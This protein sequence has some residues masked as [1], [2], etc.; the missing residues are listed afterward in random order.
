MRVPERLR[1]DVEATGTRLAGVADA[2]ARPPSRNQA[3]GA[4][5]DEL[6]SILMRFERDGFSALRADWQALDALQGRAARIV[7]GAG[8]HCGIARGIDAGGA[9][10]FEVDGGLHRFVAGDVSLRVQGPPP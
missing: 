10:L 6:I 5:L 2:S 1:R 3:A 8:A 9:L 4:I 7:S